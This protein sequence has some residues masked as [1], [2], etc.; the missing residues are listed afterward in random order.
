MKFKKFTFKFKAGNIT[1]LALHYNVA[2]V[3]AQAQAIERGWDY[4]I[5]K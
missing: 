1:V 5:I 3:L 2:A 4:N